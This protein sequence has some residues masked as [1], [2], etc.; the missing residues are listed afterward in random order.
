[1][2]VGR[3]QRVVPG[4]DQARG[5]RGTSTRRSSATRRRTSSYRGPWATADFLRERVL[6]VIA[7]ELG[8]DPID[9]RRRNYVH[10]DEPPLDDAHR[11]TV[12]RCHH[13]G[14]DRAGR[15]H[16]RL[17]RVQGRAAGAALAEGRYLGL[18]M[19]SYLEAAP[20]PKNPAG[21]ARRRHAGRRDS[22]VSVEADGS[23]TVV[24]QQHPHGQG[25]QTTL[26]Q[27]AADELGV[28]FE[29]ITVRY[30]DTDFTPFALV[31][32][33]GSRA[34]T[35]ANGSVLHASRALREKIVAVA[36][37]LLEAD[38]HDLEIRDGVVSVVGTPSITLSVRRPRSDRRRGARSAS[39][40]DVD[41]SSPR[42]RRTTVARVDG[43]A[44][45]T[46]ASSRSTSRPASSTSSATSWWRTAA[47]R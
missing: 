44:A 32:T 33:G 12:R 14:V 21:S 39:R 19:A 45:R 6:D 31:S 42:P 8:I 24:T 30:G 22:H 35:M 15:A 11:A 13:A 26:A 20:G 10:L 36:A 29:A 3:R 16:R 28:P 47:C 25:H 9:V 7:R 4:P 18:G 41:R 38:P 5:H 17:G 27:V 40:I 2:M 23:I 37:E 34:A 43:P 1:M 46:A